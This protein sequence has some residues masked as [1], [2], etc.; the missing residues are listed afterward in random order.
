RISGAT[1]VLVND[2]TGFR[3]SI[4]SDSEGR[5]AF[6]LLPPGNYTARATAQGMSPQVTPK[7]HVEIGGAAEI[8][9]KLQVAGAK[10][11]ITVSGA[12]PLVDT[13]PAAV[14]SL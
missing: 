7:L 9:F 5:F 8:D 14:S 1:I 2:A 11:T 6:E 4:A 12:P 3:Y 10:E 13:Q